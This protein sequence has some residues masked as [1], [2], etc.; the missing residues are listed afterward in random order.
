M[1]DPE[2]KKTFNSLSVE[3]WA[4]YSKYRVVYMLVC[5]LIEGK[6]IEIDGTVI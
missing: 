2:S 4:Y 6:K 5:T 1:L 3:E